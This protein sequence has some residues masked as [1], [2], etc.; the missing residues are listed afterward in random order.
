[1]QIV[2]SQKYYAEWKKPY[3]KEYVKILLIWS[4]E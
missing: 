2:E 3:M 4:L 1:M